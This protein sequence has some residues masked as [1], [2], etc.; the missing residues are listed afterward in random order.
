MFE[1]GV[2]LITLG[3]FD[4]IWSLVLFLGLCVACCLFERMTLLFKHLQGMLDIDSGYNTTALIRTLISFPPGSSRLPV[5]VGTVDENTDVFAA[6]FEVVV[7]WI[8]YFIACA[9]V[10][11]SL[12]VCMA[13]VMLSC[14]CIMEMMIQGSVSVADAVKL[15]WA[16]GTPSSK[17]F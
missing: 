1:F 15:R 4:S 14:V 17:V 16:R 10:T 11:V 12:I 6:L 9:S 5:V 2:A 7:H 3:V 13:I 8:A